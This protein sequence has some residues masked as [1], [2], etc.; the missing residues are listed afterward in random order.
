MWPCSLLW[1]FLTANAL[2]FGA[3]L[4][5]QLEHEAEAYGL[6]ASQQ[7]G[8]GA[9]SREQGTREHGARE[10]GAKEH[11]AQEDGAKEQ[12]PRVEARE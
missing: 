7:T 12:E 9:R 8:P 11:G 1:L 4:N 3:E 2:L 6:R 5:R 10:D